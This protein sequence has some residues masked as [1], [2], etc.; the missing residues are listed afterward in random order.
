MIAERLALLLRARERHLLPVP[1]GSCPHC[2]ARAGG[3]E[4]RPRPRRS[5]PQSG[6]ATPRPAE[7]SRALRAP[8]PC[9]HPPELREDAGEVEAAAAGR[10]P[11]ELVRLEDI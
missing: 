5:R 1:A 11:A 10:L 2:Q 6:R 3:E 7:R 8:R 4:A 9:V